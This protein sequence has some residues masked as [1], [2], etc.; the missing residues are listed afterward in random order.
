MCEE[1][2]IFRFA[3]PRFATLV[4]NSVL[5]GK[6]TGNLADLGFLRRFRRPIDQKIQWLAVKFPAQ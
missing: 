5:T 4:Q 3:L 1:P 2:A 6:L